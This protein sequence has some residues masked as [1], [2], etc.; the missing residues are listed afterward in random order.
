MPG[1]LL[2]RVIRLTSVLIGRKR[3]I[4][5]RRVWILPRRRHRISRLTWKLDRL[6]GILWLAGILRLWVL[7]SR[8]LPGILRLRILTG[9]R[10]TRVLLTG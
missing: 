6:T 1:I 9:R 3:I 8:R 4:L 5:L 7:T 2:E 10:L